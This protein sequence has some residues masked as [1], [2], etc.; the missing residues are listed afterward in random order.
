MGAKAQV[1]KGRIKE[2]AG[3]LTGNDKLRAQGEADEAIAKAKIATQKAISK[4]AKATRKTVNKTKTAQ[5]LILIS[6]II[7]VT[8]LSQSIGRA[9]GNRGGEHAGA[10]GG[11]ASGGR[12]DLGNKSP[13]QNGSGTAHQDAGVVH[14][15]VGVQNPSPGSTLAHTQPTFIRNNSR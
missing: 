2:A 13:P 5:L 6:M 8:M 9:Q 10:S 3:A 12:E 14:N 11:R 7:A 4:I 1:L 15:G